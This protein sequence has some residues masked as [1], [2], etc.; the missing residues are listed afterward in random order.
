ML[1]SNLTGEFVFLYLF[2]FL[3]YYTTNKGDPI[4]RQVYKQMQ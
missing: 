3:K 1:F 2:E 4:S